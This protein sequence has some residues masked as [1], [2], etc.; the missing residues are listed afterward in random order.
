MA[1]S[2][3]NNSVKNSKVDLIKL[4]SNST[5]KAFSKDTTVK[6]QVVNARKAA[7]INKE[8][9][10]KKAKMAKASRKKNKK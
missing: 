3:N 6:D 9:A 4:G 2:Q 8:K 1:K 10:K 5:P 7:S